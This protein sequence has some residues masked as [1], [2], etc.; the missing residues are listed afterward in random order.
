MFP[1]FRLI[2]ME[3][4][5]P[6]LLVLIGI[7]AVTLGPASVMPAEAVTLQEYQKVSVSLPA[8]AVVP[9]GVMVTNDNGETEPLDGLIKRPTVLVLSNFRCKTLCGPILDFVVSALEQSG[10]R[11][12]KQFSVLVVGLDPR[13]A[14][15][16]ARTMRNEHLSG[17]PTL[18]DA[19]T[20]VRSDKRSLDRLTTAFGYHYVY[21]RDTDQFIHPAAAF[22]L[23]DDRRVSRVLT[24]VG[25]SG[26][27][28]RL[29]LV[30]AGQGKIGN[31]SDKVHLLCSAFDPAQ[32]IYTP[33]IN[34]TL[35]VSSTATLVL[36]AGG[37][38]F[39][40]FSNCR[41]AQK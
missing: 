37:I 27:D 7:V 21:D 30:E 10:L 36:L 15:D 41:S 18:N 19:I 31:L 8:E 22:V 24:G 40:A 13:D 4:P 20:F 28:M 39:L 11:A 6:R 34:R 5:L 32:G 14:T 9:A 33:L 1:P 25:L 38:G 16:D 35:M 26:E 3:I 2:T 12:G 23:R 29:A 17:D